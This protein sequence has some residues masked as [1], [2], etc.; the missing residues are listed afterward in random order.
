[1]S[2]GGTFRGWDKEAKL[3]RYLWDN[4][5]TSPFE[6]AGAI[7]EVKAPIFVFREWHRHRTQSFNEL[8]ARYTQVP[9]DHYVPFPERLIVSS[10]TNKQA[11]QAVD[12]VLTLEEAEEWVKDLKVVYEAAERL[13]CKGLSMGLPKEAAR[14]IMPVGRYSVMRASANLLN[15][16]RFLRLR[17]HLNPGAQMEI[18]SYANVIGAAL[19]ETFPR[20][21]CMLWEEASD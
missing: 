1:M 4:N 21:L 6:M 5:H 13:Y 17:S 19:Q 10:K 8:S 9:A 16:V 15:W 11:G 20:T 3:L 2:T 7:F 14:L 12:K 18:Q